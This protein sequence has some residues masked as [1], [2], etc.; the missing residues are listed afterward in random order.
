[1]FLS[2]SVDLLS[3]ILVLFLGLLIWALYYLNARYTYRLHAGSTE[4]ATQL[5]LLLGSV[6]IFVLQVSLMCRLVPGGAH[7][8]SFKALVLVEVGGAFVVGL[9]T[10]L[11]ERAKHVKAPAVDGSGNDRML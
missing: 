2:Q 5:V 6:C 10:L 7:R 11:W 4:T 9:G 1:M 3:R 8:A